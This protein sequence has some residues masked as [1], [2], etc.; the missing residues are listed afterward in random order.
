M[1]DDIE[2]RIKKIVV[3]SLK[4]DPARVKGDA[5]FTDDLGADSL[6]LVE[7]VMAFEDEFGCEIPDQ[8]AEKIVKFSD[9]VAYVKK[10]KEEMA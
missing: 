6:D 4:V 3:D 9:A 7:L 5:K 1:S 8:D 10:V 2:E